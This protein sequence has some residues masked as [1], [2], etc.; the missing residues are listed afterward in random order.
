MAVAGSA[1][2]VVVTAIFRGPRTRSG[3]RLTPHPLPLASPRQQ[4]DVT[5]HI[6]GVRFVPYHDMQAMQAMLGVAASVRYCE[7][8]GAG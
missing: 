3:T 5:Q 4:I 7:M 1:L 8:L 6:E 2:D